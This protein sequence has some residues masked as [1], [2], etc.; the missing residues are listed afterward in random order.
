MMKRLLRTICVVVA[1][2]M[3]VAVPVLAQAWFAPIQFQ[4]TTGTSYDMFPAR[5]P[6]NTTWNVDHGYL[7][8]TALDSQVRTDG[9]WVNHMMA[10]DKLMFAY[11]LAGYS[12]NPLTLYTGGTPLA[13]FDMIFGWNGYYTVSDHLTLELGLNEFSLYWGDTWVDTDAGIAR[14]M[15]NKVRSMSV[16]TSQTTDEQINLVVCGV[17]ENC[18]DFVRANVDWVRVPDDAAFSFTDGAGNDEPFTFIAWVNLDDATDSSVITKRVGGQNE[19][20][21]TTDAAD[22]L[23]VAC[24][25]LAGANTIWAETV[26]ITGDQGAWHHYAATYDGTEANTG[27]ELY[28]D[29]TN[30]TN[31]RGGLG[32]YVGMADGTS[33]V[34]VGSRA[35]GAAQRMDGLMA[36]IKVYNAELTQTEI[37]ADYN[38][39]HRIADLV[40]WWRI[41]EGVGLP[42]DSSGNGHHANQNLAD[43]V[44]EFTS[45]DTIETYAS[46]VASGELDLEVAR[47]DEPAMSLWA[48]DVNIAV[49]MGQGILPV[50]LI[51][52]ITLDAPAASVTFSNIDTNVA[53]WDSLAGVTSRH[54]VVMVNA[55]SDEV[56]DSRD[57]N[58]QFNGDGAGN[59]NWQRLTGINNVDAA[60]SSTGVTS[61]QTG[62]IPATNFANAFG[63][64]TILIPHAFNTSNHKAVISLTG[65]AEERVVASTGRWASNNAVTSILLYPNAGNFD[66]GSTF[67]LGV[68]DERYL[69]EEAINPAADFVVDFNNIPQDGHDL[70]VVGYV[71]SDRAI[72]WDILFHE[73]NNDAV[74][75]NYALQYLR[76]LGAVPTAAQENSLLISRCT[77]DA[78]GANEFGSIVASYSQ[79]AEGTNDPHF[80]AIGGYLESVGGGSD[81]VVVSGRRNN[82][83]AITRLEYYPNAGVNFKAGSLFSLYRVPRYVIDRQELTVAAPTI[84]FA[85]IPQDYQALQLNVYARSNKAA[86]LD[87]DVE[88]TLNTDAGPATYDWQYV[89]GT[90][91][92]PPTAARNL[93]SLVVM[94]VPAAG[95]GANEFGG[96]VVTFPRYERTDG[97]KHFLTLSGTQENQV[98]LRSSRWE[99]LSAITQIDLDLAG[100]NNFIAGSVFE[101]VG[102]MPSKVFDITVGTE[103]KGLSDGNLGVPDVVGTDWYSNQDNVLPYSGN[104]THTVSDVMHAW[105]EPNTYVSGITLVDRSYYGVDFDGT[106]DRIDCGN[107]ATLSPT[108]AITIEAWVNYDNAVNFAGIASR[109][110][111]Y[112]LRQDAGG[113]FRLLLYIDGAWRDLGVSVLVGTDTWHH[114]VATYDSSTRQGII[115]TNGT[116]GA[117]TTLGG[118]ASY[119]IVASAGNTFLGFDGLNSVYLDGTLDEL[120][121]YSRAISQ[122][123]V[124]ANY[125]AGVGA[126]T[127]SDTTGLA[128]WWHMEEGSGVT[129]ADS[130]GNGNTGTLV[131]GPLW[132]NGHVPRPAGN[133]GTNDGTIFWGSNPTGVSVTLGPL[134]AYAV[135]AFVPGELVTPD[136][137]G[138]LNIA[139]AEGDTAY[140]GQGNLF[141]SFAQTMATGT[142]TP[143]QFFWGVLCLIFVLGCMIGVARFAPGNLAGVAFAGVGAMGVCVA[144]A[145]IPW[146]FMLI[147]AAGALGLMAMERSPSM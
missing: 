72:A 128:G 137:A 80:L 52:E 66:T 145:F 60:F 94:A 19:W 124:T 116:A 34:D 28:R 146:W 100:A 86:V 125:N 38:G 53:L 16:R 131:L 5:T 2:L 11:P 35:A 83:V 59:Y 101:L 81:L 97:H 134:A 141:Y 98:I 79:Y 147:P 88:I 12:S 8:S 45:R 142:N 27:L 109:M 42:Q 122:A 110:S 82:V 78:A 13:S 40:A 102:V 64:G 69:V 44:L 107:D 132:V 3:L 18:L 113:N 126:Y 32:V 95:E 136:V 37:E 9:G 115:Y 51:E 39:E 41:D 133:S 117:P 21:F 56:A 140:E 31:A 26:A 63:G 96:G 29:G 76:G 111:S 138:D 143:I 135:P 62:A 112:T 91:A 7:T 10:D 67:L 77:G 50:K 114:L 22:L 89:E 1:L 57:L 87:E 46:N 48:S 144:M 99:N 129:T 65:A 33:N 123:E 36:E 61:I 106:N 119:T 130:S 75:A 105:Y 118:L 68:I 127:P 74:G 6:F 84:T 73:I 139:M 55:I 58:L 24:M 71:R 20:H 23:E 108:S 90:G 17:D 103:V 30:A 92:G 85:N 104:Y 4:E 15:V 47:E 93:A 121:V 70:V 49:N 43:W 54:L 14:I 25:D 120:R